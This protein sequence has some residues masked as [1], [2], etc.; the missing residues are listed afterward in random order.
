MS[1][2]YTDRAAITRRLKAQG[3][4][5]VADD[6]LDG[7]VDEDEL[8]A[9]IDDAIASTEAIIDAAISPHVEPAHARAAGNRWLMD[10]A[11]HIACYIAAT[12]GG[13]D[14]NEAMKDHYDEAM[15][16]LDQVK[17]GSTKIP[18]FIYPP[19]RGRTPTGRGPRV[20]NVV[21]PRR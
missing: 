8:V 1:T 21:P 3:L 17:S 2:S 18:N 20:I 4:L 19:A 5:F 16:M 11:T 10:R 14:V 7:E 13:R 12:N 6:D 9:S 15:T